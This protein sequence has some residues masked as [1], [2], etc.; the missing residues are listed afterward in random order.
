VWGRSTWQ[1]SSANISVYLW[2]SLEMASHISRPVPQ[3][4]L[5]AGW[6]VLVQEPNFPV[7]PD[8]RCWQPRG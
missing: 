4:P 7:T 3:W 6:Q 2:V 1:A 5:S 8:P